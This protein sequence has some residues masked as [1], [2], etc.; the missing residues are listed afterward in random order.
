MKWCREEHKTNQVKKEWQRSQDQWWVWLREASKDLHQLCHLLH[1]K[2]LRGKPDTKVKILWVRKLKCMIERGNLLSAVTPVTSA[3]DSLKKNTHQAY[4]EWILMKL[5]LLMSEKSDELMDD[6]TGKPV[7]CSQRGAPQHFV[8][9]DDEAESD[10]SLESRS[11]LH[12]V[13]GQGAKK[14]KTI[15]NGCNSK[16]WRAFCDSENVHVFNTASI[17]IHGENFLRQLAF[18]KNS[19]DLTMK[20]MFD[21]SGKLISEQ[22]DEIYGVKT[23]NWESFSWK[24]LSLIGDE[25]VI[26]LQRTKVYVF[27]DSVLC[28]GKIHE[29]PQSNGAWEDRLEWFKSAPECRKF[30]RIDGE[31]MEFEWTLFPGFS[32]LQFSHKVQDLLLRLVSETPE[33]FTGRIVFMS[34]FN[35]IS[36]D[37]KTTRKDANQMLNSFLHLQKKKFRSRTIVISRSCFREKVAFHQWR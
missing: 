21:T 15:L 34:M 25:Q 14:K 22:S 9:E 18:L 16:Q 1:Q 5:G 29:N 28:L 23:I 20:Q 33:N 12:R 27:S 36:W 10:L 37:R 2:A 32:T 11:F 6:K 35:D 7:V 13:N 19:K 31:P 4:S 26:S 24:Y 17:C 3:T 30:D 8:I